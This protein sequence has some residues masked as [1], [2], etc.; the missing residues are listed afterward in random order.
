MKIR[1]VD[2]DEVI[3]DSTTAEGGILGACKVFEGYVAKRVAATS[4]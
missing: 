2:G 1:F 4:G 3:A